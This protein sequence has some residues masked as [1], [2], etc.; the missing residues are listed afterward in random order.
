ME[1]AT[2]SESVNHLGPASAVELLPR[3]VAPREVSEEETPV[4]ANVRPLQ[5]ARTQWNTAKE[6]YYRDLLMWQR[7][8]PNVRNPTATSLLIPNSNGAFCDKATE[9]T[10]TAPEYGLVNYLNL[11]FRPNAF[12][13]FRNEFYDDYKGQ[14]SGYATDYS[15]NTIGV[16]WFIGSV[17]E[18][19]PELR[20]DYSYKRPAFDG[21]R[22]W[23]Q[24]TAATDAIFFY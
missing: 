6:T 10:C 5:F 21:G 18:I 2:T 4:L 15:E 19:R 11:Q 20:F 14:R 12:L 9:L 17:I 1:T 23:G 13:S 22:K 16:T 3:F 7:D 8:V 24:F